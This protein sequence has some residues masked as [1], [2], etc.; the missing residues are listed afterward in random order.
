LFWDAL[1][2]HRTDGAMVRL[3]TAVPSTADEADADRRLTEV[4]SRIAPELP[5][6]VPH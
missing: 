2:R 4:A 3:I 1:T 5:R 6:Y